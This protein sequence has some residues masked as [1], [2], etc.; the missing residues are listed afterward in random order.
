LRFTSVASVLAF[1]AFH[2][3]EELLTQPLQIIVGNRVGGFGSYRHGQELF[4]RATCRKDL[5]VVDGASH[6]DLYD[7]PGP[8]GRAVAKLAAFYAENLMG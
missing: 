4:R 5:F 2:L 7:Q 1:D 3:V 6:Y 8:V